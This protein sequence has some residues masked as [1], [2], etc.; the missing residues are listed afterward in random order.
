MSD[1]FRLQKEIIDENT[2]VLHCAG[3][4][5]L[6]S[7]GEFRS[8]VIELTSQKT[9]TVIVDLAGV[10]YMDSS[11]LGEL[12]SGFTAARNR[13]GYLVLVSPSKRVRDILTI[14]KLNSVFEI[15]DSIDS[16]LLGGGTSRAKK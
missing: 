8:V 7:G 1:Q 4:W 5:V 10:S 13:G 9:K 6:G 11:S 16:A 12:V 14:T 3:R 2:A 15:Y